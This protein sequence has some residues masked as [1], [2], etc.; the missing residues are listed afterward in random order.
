MAETVGTLRPS[1][2]VF[3]MPPDK[4]KKSRKKNWNLIY[5]FIDARNG[6]QASTI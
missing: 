5:Q 2:R 3:M 6:G 4:K 1:L